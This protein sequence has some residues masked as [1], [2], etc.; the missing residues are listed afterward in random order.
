MDIAAMREEVDRIDSEMLTLIAR[1]VEIARQIWQARR[2]AG[3][4][5][6]DSERERDMLERAR[7]THSDVLHARDRVLFTAALLDYTRNVVRRHSRRVQPRSIAIIGLGLI[8]G[9]LAAAL[10]AAQPDHVLTGVDLQDRLA[11]PRQSGLFEALYEPAQGAQ[12]VR[13]AEVVFL[14]VPHAR[15][16]ELMETLA[17][18]VPTKATITDV[19]GLK[20]TIVQRACEVFSFPDAAYF[21]GGHPMAGK[22]VSGF[23]NMDSSLFEGRPWILTPDPS[24]PVDKLNVLKELIESTG[25]LVR[26]MDPSTHDQ[27]MTVVSHLPQIAATALMLTAGDEANGIAGPAFM[28]MTRIAGS[29]PEMWNELVRPVREELTARLQT[30]KAYLTELEMAISFSDSLS[31]WMSR[32]STLRTALEKD[33]ADEPGDAHE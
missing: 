26:L 1:R 19:C 27:S 18:D 15:V 7:T 3:E 16:L 13:R 11:Q 25:A 24:D 21:V 30:F 9:S 4:P 17:D 29:P 22:A 28:D 10:K 8:G 20:R 12:A 32:A 5:S 14:C 2:D 31:K 23:E 6:R 33:S